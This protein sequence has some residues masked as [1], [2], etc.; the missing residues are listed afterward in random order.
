MPSTRGP[1]RVS[2]RAPSP[3]GPDAKTP[4]PRPRSCRNTAPTGA[5]GRQSHR[6]LGAFRGARHAHPKRIRLVRDIAV[7]K[8]PPLQDGKERLVRQA[9]P[10]PYALAVKIIHGVVLFG[11]GVSLAQTAAAGHGGQREH[12][13]R[14][15]RVRARAQT[16]LLDPARNLV[17]VFLQCGQQNSRLAAAGK[18]GSYILGAK[19][20]AFSFSICKMRATLWLS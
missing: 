5:A 6:S 4:R 7:Q 14:H 8:I 17:Q 19:P 16:Q 12:L 10:P 20:M 15:A 2:D 9:I 1:R 13:H 18:V 3:R 11:N